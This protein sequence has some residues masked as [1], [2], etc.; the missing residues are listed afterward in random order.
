[1]SAASAPGIPQ[2]R[3]TLAEPAVCAQNVKGVPTS[4]AAQI[5]AS[6]RTTL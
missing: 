5:G 1:M 4:A 3:R 6:T 2:T